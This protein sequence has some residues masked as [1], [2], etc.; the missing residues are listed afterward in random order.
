MGKHDTIRFILPYLPKY[1]I[2]Y[3]PFSVCIKFTLDERQNINK[4]LTS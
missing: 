1:V 2:K 4:A 3:L